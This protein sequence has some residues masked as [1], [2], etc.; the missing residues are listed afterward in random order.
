M[1]HR[2]S[3][4]SSQVP[5]P[6]A[7]EPGDKGEVGGQASRERREQDTDNILS[8]LAGFRVTITAKCVPN[9]RF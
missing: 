4:V 7:R 2:L 8:D 3:N 9:S 6:V 5:Q 1:I